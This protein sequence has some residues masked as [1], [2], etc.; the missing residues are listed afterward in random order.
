MCASS[1]DPATKRSR[2]RNTHLT[3]PKIGFG[4]GLNVS[5]WQ[6]RTFNPTTF[7]FFFFSFFLSP[8]LA[9][10]GHLWFR[11][12]KERPEIFAR[13]VAFWKRTEGYTACVPGSRR[14]S[15]S[16]QDGRTYQLRVN[17]SEKQL[18]KV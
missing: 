17:L 5:L 3:S 2:A 13:R 12:Y 6:C 10:V 18:R 7:F 8:F 14:W 1:H 15:C 11:V 4:Y 9:T 16:L